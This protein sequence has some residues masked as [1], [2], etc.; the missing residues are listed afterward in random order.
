MK[1][2]QP[3]I[4][5]EYII[6]EGSTLVS[7]TDLAGTIIECNEA[8]EL[9]SGFKRSELIGQPHNIIRHP[10]VPEA[11]F[12]DLWA[13]LKIGAPW[14]QIVKNRRANGGFYWVVARAT[15]I[16]ENGQIS[17]YMSVRSPATSEQKAAASQ[18]YKDIKDGK[19][20]I[21]NA[22]VIHGF[23]WHGLNLFPKLNPQTQLMILISIFYLLPVM[24]YAYISGYGVLALSLIAVLGLLPPY[25]YGSRRQKSSQ[26]ASNMLH[27]IASKQ[28]LLKDWYDPTEFDGRL[29]SA[30]TEA[31]LAS[32]EVRED[33][34]FQQDMANRQ[35]DAIDK[36]S[37]N[38]M[39][40][41]I[42]FNI[43]YMNQTMKHF[44]EVREEHLKAALPNFNSQTILG[45]NIDIFHQHPEHNRHL[46]KELAE[47]TLLNITI[48]GL[49]LTLHIIPVYNRTGAQTSTLVEWQDNTAEVQLMEQVN[50]TVQ[51]AQ[52]GQLDQRIDLN[53]VQGVAQELSQS[54]NNLLDTVSAPINEVVKVAI[55]LSQGNLTH[56]VEGD[57]HGRFAVMQDSLNVALNNMASMIA[58]SKLA[59]SNVSSDA[60]EIQQG[61]I[62]L[63]DRTQ[64]QASSLEETATNIKQM[65]ETV[66]QNAENSQESVVTTHNTVEQAKD[67]VKVM[68]NA[69][70]SM[71]QITE[72]SKQI[73]D[74]I[75]LIDSIAFQTNLLALNAAVEAARAGEHG[76]GFAVVA[77]EVRNLAGKSA[78]AAKEIRG[79]IEDTVH[80]ITEGTQ[81][82]QGSSEALNRI[83]QSIT[84]VSQVMDDIASSSQEQKEGID[85]VNVAISQIDSA[86]QEN[87]V[88]AKH[89]ATTSEELNDLSL[90]MKSNMAQFTID[91]NTSQPSRVRSSDD[92]DFSLARR[93]L[94]QWQIIARSYL[95][96]ISIPFDRSTAG[97]VEKCSLGQWLK[98]D[99]KTYQSLT[100]VQALEKEHAKFHQFVGETLH[101]KDAGD[102]D[103][104]N[105][106]MNK[107]AKKVDKVIE[108]IDQVEQ[109]IATH[110]NSKV[111]P[112]R[113]TNL[114]ANTPK[115][116]QN[117]DNNKPSIALPK[118]SE[119]KNDEWADF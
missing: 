86:V 81:L 36:V 88:L 77:G 105:E 28:E 38:V 42:D 48:A 87:S 46:L 71:E 104:A 51:A 114:I 40:A 73:N 99:G 19:A 95:N 21:K 89:T 61:S 35:Q 119:P 55:G 13:T 83:V 69:I 108:L 31:G 68:H 109:D 67:G 82:V 72:S 6:P 63:N 74:I 9:A 117:S 90:V 80:K 65:A 97:N 79:L 93:N 8:F 43:I 2:N 98:G 75:G 103:K 12:A 53:L 107:L 16:F 85:Q 3:I 1:N 59:A 92:F 76:K 22:R 11:V 4:N 7:K 39:I 106:I 66:K 57:L 37:S 78:E 27:T 44:L 34:A 29:E 60:I 50:T 41:D 47:P 64:T 45:S 116:V 25:I 32:L 26:K 96:D 49:H 70:I 14:S 58:E 113:P 115:P 23:D 62:N 110:K 102:L 100:S 20:R 56:T 112:T 33:S 15:P 91:R 94:R 52:M 111:S 30:I 5:E 118:Q 17:G 54:I 101:L 18:I 10:D 84:E 24:I